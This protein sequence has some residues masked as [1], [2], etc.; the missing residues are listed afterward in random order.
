M[1]SYAATKARVNERA[2]VAIRAAVDAE[3]GNVGRGTSARGAR[4]S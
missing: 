1:P 4:E 3:L 2:L